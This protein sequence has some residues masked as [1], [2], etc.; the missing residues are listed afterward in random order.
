MRTTELIRESNMASR[1]SGSRKGKKA[2]ALVKDDGLGDSCMLAVAFLTHAKPYLQ[3]ARELIRGKSTLIYPQYFLL[4]HAMELV[5][6]SYLA[7]QGAT[8]SELR[9]LRHDLLLAYARARKKGFVPSDARIPEIIRWM[10][11]FHEELV[12]RYHKTS[13]TVQLPVSNELA[14]VVSGLILQVEP[15]VRGRFRANRA[16]S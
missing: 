10:S 3:A 7:C 5:L 12:F 2:K 8:E 13:R 15:V 11:P 9:G 6:K 4:C 16:S 1:P 14:D